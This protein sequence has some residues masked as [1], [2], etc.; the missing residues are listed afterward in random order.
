MKKKLLN[1]LISVSLSAAML[2]GSVYTVPA[3]DFTSEEIV[4]Q[5]DDGEAFGDPTE[6]ST[7]SSVNSG[8]TEDEVIIEDENDFSDDSSEENS[9]LE[10]TLD[11]EDDSAD[12]ETEM[13]LEE[14]TEFDDST[15][16]EEAAFD[17]NASLKEGRCGKNLT[18]RIS[19]DHI[20]YID[21]TG[22]MDDGGDNSM[23]DVCGQF[24]VL[25]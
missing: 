2:A 17:A 14:E 8:E 19:A 6:G 5:S 11:N 16:G 7:E 21:G 4:T 18:W 24:A 13:I 3:A 22:D 25:L 9:E 1:Q 10:I 12:T 15:S 20:L 23:A